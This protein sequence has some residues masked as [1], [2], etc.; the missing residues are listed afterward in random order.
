MFC[1]KNLGVS[2]LAVGD[3]PQSL[4]KSDYERFGSLLFRRVGEEQKGLKHALALEQ[5]QGKPLIRV[6][7]RLHGV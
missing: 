5:H 6:S 2:G 1:F 7:P 4:L 3:P